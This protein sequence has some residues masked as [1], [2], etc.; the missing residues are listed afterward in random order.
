MNEKITEQVN[1]LLGC[2][3]DCNLRWSD[4]TYRRAIAIQ[5]LFSF[6][7]KNDKSNELRAEATKLAS[8]EPSFRALESL[9]TAVKKSS[10]EKNGSSVKLEWNPRFDHEDSLESLTLSPT[11]KIEKID[12]E[13]IMEEIARLHGIISSVTVR[14]DMLI[15]YILKR[16][17]EEGYA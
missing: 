15:S 14:Y 12:M 7:A 9:L 4:L 11:F 17:T 16:A 1:Y 3:D 6:F 8:L 5:I 13:P 2:A 10:E